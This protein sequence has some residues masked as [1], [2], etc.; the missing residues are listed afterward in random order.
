MPV[1]EPPDRGPILIVA[2]HPDDMESWCGGTIARS[3]IAGA[4]AELLLVTSGDKGSQDPDTRPEE[5]ARTRE[6]EAERAAEHLGIST[7]HFLR[8]RDGEVEDTI[9]LRRQLVEIVRMVRPAVIFTFD[10][11]HPLPPYTSHRDHRLVG[12]VTLDVVY[13]L[14][15]DP[16]NF[17]EQLKDGLEPHKTHEVWLFASGVADSYVDISEGFERK[18]IA[19][20]AHTSQTPDPASLPENWQRRAAERGADAGLPMAEAFTILSIR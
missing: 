16:L 4:R 12:R 9:E 3:I 10:P 15:R 1:V 7:V 8:H 2:A 5:L 19:R 14:A 13:P 6:A 18:V 11:V 17:P 20:L